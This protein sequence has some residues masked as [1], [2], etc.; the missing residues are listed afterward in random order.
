[1]RS[2]GSAGVLH[3]AH[4][5]NG[6]QSW[7]EVTPAATNA[8][9]CQV[10]ASH[11]DAASALLIADVSDGDASPCSTSLS[12]TQDDGTSWRAIPPPQ[13]YGNDCAAGYGWFADTIFAS[14][15]ADPA[16]A[17]RSVAMWQVGASTEWTTASAGAGLVL[18]EV[19]GMRSSGALLG[20][21]LST[22]PHVGNGRLMGSDDRGASWYDIGNLP[23]PNTALFMDERTPASGAS[24]Q[25]IYAIS[26]KASQESQDLPVRTLWRWNDE[27]RLWVA[28][29]D[30]PRIVSVPDPLTQP[31]TAVVGVGP[32]G[33]LLISAPITMSVTG[34]P[35]NRA[36]WYWADTAQRWTRNEAASA[37]GAYL[38]G[39]GWSGNAATLWLIYLHLGVPPHLELF[40]TRFTA[41]SLRLR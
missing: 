19:T 21:A 9:G 41:D 37:P 32:D 2:P 27:R 39:L 28:L 14:A 30:I 12:L 11:E 10:A 35:A 33:G 40:T 4:T 13:A 23:G 17:P 18:T 1:V 25:P 15:G 22:D 36:F 24:A 20:A 3:A 26:D 8:R 38:Y 16:T 7:R 31:E 34:E 29:P 5:L 6:G